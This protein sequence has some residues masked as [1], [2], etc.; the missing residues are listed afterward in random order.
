MPSLELLG[1]LCLALGIS[2]RESRRLRKLLAEQ[3]V[4]SSVLRL[5]AIGDRIEALADRIEAL[6][7][8]VERLEKRNGR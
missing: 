6:T 8:R 7:A 4:R 2:E 5:T 3:S 1:R